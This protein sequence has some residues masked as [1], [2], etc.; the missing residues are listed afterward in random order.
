MTCT[1]ATSS[2]RCDG[3]PSCHGIAR[4]LAGVEPGQEKDAL[5]LG[6]FY[7]E[8]GVVAHRV[9]WHRESQAVYDWIRLGPEWIRWRRPELAP[10]FIRT[11]RNSFDALNLIGRQV[12]G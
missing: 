1:F 9:V 6:V 12:V 3:S 2:W 5:K 4:I 7:G 8:G 10:E 11:I